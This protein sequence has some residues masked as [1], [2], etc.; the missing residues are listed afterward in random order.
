MRSE[1]DF[2][3][4]WNTQQFIFLVMYYC[5]IF[6]SKFETFCVGVRTIVP[7]TF[8]HERVLWLILKMRWGYNSSNDH[9]I[10]T[11]ICWWKCAIC[12]TIL[13]HNALYSMPVNSSFGTYPQFKCFARSCVI[14]EPHLNLT[15]LLDFGS[16]WK[17][18]KVRS[19]SGR[20]KFQIVQV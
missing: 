3:L 17:E 11:Y 4:S 5:I 8:W 10:L 6:C 7:L 12:C 2:P 20:T 18:W 19:V 1:P 16:E 9:E 13:L 14:T 15:I